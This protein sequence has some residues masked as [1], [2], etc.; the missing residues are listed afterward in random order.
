MYAASSPNRTSAVG[1]TDLLEEHLRPVHRVVM[2]LS[3][4]LLDGL[5]GVQGSLYL[6][7]DIV[8][9]DICGTLGVARSC[10]GITD[11]VEDVLLGGSI[12]KVQLGPLRVGV[13]TAGS[14]GNEDRSTE[15]V[16]QERHPGLLLEW[17]TAR[18]GSEENEYS[19]QG[20]IQFGDITQSLTRRQFSIVPLSSSA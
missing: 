11:C 15:V 8:S 9:S 2:F 19:R 20:L 18:S 7:R 6:S 12:D 3:C 13:A 4:Q 1:K 16:A 5:A 14:R 10:E 17:F